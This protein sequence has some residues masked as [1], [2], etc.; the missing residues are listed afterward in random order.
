MIAR[1]YCDETLP[2][3]RR[4]TVEHVKKVELSYWKTDRIIDQKMDKLEI[5]LDTNE[6]ESDIE[7]DSAI[8]HSM[9]F[10]SFISIEV[11]RGSIPALASSC[12]KRLTVFFCLLI[13]FL[14]I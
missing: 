12:K 1:S 9:G 7:T 10:G 5:A 13:V 4:Q 8:V 2:N 11:C 6:D 14:K 3:S